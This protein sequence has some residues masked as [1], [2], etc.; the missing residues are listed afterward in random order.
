VLV[1]RSNA[2]NDWLTHRHARPEDLWFHAHGVPGSHVVLRREGRK[3]NP[4]ARTLEE[5]AAIAAFYSKAR[6]SSKTPV[7]Y[8]LRKHV[9][10]P[11]GARPGLAVCEREKMIMVRPKDPAEG[12]EPE[13]MED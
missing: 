8:T 1:G 13:W 5:A 2:E 9:R 7:I 10:K 6:H 12:R 11:R 3:S 4:S